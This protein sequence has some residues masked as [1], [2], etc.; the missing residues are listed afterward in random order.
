MSEVFLAQCELSNSEKAAWG[1]GRDM[2]RAERASERECV[3][4]TA[5]EQMYYKQEHVVWKKEGGKHITRVLL[6]PHVYRRGL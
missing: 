5:N 4:G 3:V 6:P 2:S 1:D